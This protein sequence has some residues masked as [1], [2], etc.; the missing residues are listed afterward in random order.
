VVVSP[1]SAIAIEGPG[2]ATHAGR[3]GPQSD[4]RV[5][6]KQHDRL[7]ALLRVDLS[8]RFFPD[9]G[10][11]F[12]SGLPW[13]RFHQRIAQFKN[14]MPMSFP[15]RQTTSQERFGAPGTNVI[16]KR[17]PM[18]ASGKRFILAPCCEIS[19]IRHS[20]SVRPSSVTHA[21]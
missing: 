12:K 17:L 7:G 2:F 10:R 6:R 13:H 3:I 18:G 16:S 20:W 1:P 21:D 5:R 9:D 4:A 14:L 11:D 15:R 8:G 19:V